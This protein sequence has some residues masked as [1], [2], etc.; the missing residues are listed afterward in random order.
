MNH[1]S[2][3]WFR[4]LLKL[5]ENGWDTGKANEIS[6]IY[7]NQSDLSKAAKTL[8]KHKNKLYKELIKL[9]LDSYLVRVMGSQ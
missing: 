8:N 1:H 7:L 2:A 5:V 6:N 9:N 4:E 3:N